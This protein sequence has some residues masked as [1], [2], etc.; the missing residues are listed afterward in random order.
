MCL[1]GEPRCRR[2]EATVKPRVAVRAH[3]INCRTLPQKRL[4]VVLRV[5]LHLG[6]RIAAEVTRRPVVWVR[7]VGVETMQ[8]REL[9]VALLWA[10]TVVVVHS[11]VVSRDMREIA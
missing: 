7:I 11:T 3:G 9:L 1:V 8:R 4:S 10:V 6:C 2:G 5:R